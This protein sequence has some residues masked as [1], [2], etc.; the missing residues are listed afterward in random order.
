MQE[1]RECRWY[2]EELDTNAAGC[3]KDMPDKF[4]NGDVQCPHFEDISD[5]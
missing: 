4:W 2:W 1:C 5:R 3:N